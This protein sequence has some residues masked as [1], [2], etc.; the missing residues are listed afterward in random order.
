MP[1]PPPPGTAE[2]QLPMADRK[3]HPKFPSGEGRLLH[4]KAAQVSFMP[5]FSS[6]HSGYEVGSGEKARE[7]ILGL[8]EQEGRRWILRLSD[9]S[10]DSV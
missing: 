4:S 5:A 6:S 7:A 8:T 10:R 3:P 1:R 9:R 2:L